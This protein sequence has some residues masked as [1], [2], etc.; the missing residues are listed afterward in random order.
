M[1][2]TARHGTGHHGHGSADRQG[3]P[4]RTGAK[5]TL[6]CLTGCAIGEL[7]GMAIGTTLGW[8]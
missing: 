2:H 6:H 8:G 5:A 4:W 7:L 3:L 1:D